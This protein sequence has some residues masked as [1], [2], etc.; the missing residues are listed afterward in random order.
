MIRPLWKDFSIPTSTSIIKDFFSGAAV[1]LLGFPVVAV[2]GQICDLLSYLIFGMQP[3]EQ[4]AVRY[5]KMT[6]SSMPMLFV[7][8]FSILIAAPVIEEF[9]FRGML[10][11][12]LKSRLGT[13]AAILLSSLAFS[14][15]HMAA[16]Q[17]LGNISVVVSLF[18]FACFLGFIYEKRG[19]LFASIGLHMTFNTIST[20]RI[21]FFSES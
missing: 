13:K 10:Q 11:S 14:L 21:L 19:S 5:L 12:W 1:W 15:F 2:T 20:F 8:L 6:L 18:S 3:Y 7:A 4:V 9:L 17:G 16:S